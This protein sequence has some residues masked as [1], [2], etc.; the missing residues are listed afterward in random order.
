MLRY[1]DHSSAPKEI[2]V[3][4][5]ILLCL[6]TC[7][8]NIK[9]TYNISKR[10]AVSDPRPIILPTSDIGSVQGREKAGQPRALLF[11]FPAVFI[12]RFFLR[13]LFQS[14]T[15][16][17]CS[18][19]LRPSRIFSNMPTSSIYSMLSQ[20]TPV[21]PLPAPWKT[22]FFCLFAIQFPQLHLTSHWKRQ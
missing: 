12:S 14:L 6:S 15:S 21:F 17:W 13:W 7:I 22:T 4:Q 3:I 10:T 18:Y 20:A 16:Q 5:W 11:Q 19:F 2:T 1:P 9:L 8:L